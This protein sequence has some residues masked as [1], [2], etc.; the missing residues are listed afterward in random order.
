[1]KLKNV[2]SRNLKALA[3]HYE[4]TLTNLKIWFNLGQVFAFAASFFI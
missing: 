2:N 3:M 4:K 1:M